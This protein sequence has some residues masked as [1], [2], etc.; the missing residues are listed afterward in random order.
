MA[1]TITAIATTIKEAFM[2]SETLQGL[3]GFAGTDSFDDIFSPVS[4]EAIIID[5]I[6][7]EMATIENLFTY[8]K[9]DITFQVENERYGYK[10]W[11]V[12]KS[13]KF[14]YGDSFPDEGLEYETID[15]EKQIVKY[16][17]CEDIESGIGLLLKVVKVVN[18]NY[19][20]LEPDELTAFTSYINR[21]KPAGVPIKVRSLIGDALVL[22]LKVV[23][24]PLVINSS[25][26]LISDTN[27]YPIRDAIQ[28]YLKSIDFN[29]MFVGMKLIDEIQKVEGV[30]IA[31]IDLATANFAGISTTANGLYYKPYAGY[32]TLDVEEDLTVEMEV[33]Q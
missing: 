23:Y 2:A 8:H 7:T 9:Q 24:D 20:A 4:I 6:A 26:Q 25:G 11:F 18:N 14:Q 5:N 21:I 29:G 12:D 13:L 19:A 27:I 3:Y 22:S 28:N 32:L 10:Q 17:A 33:K 15:T 1:R 16:A 30:E 31:L